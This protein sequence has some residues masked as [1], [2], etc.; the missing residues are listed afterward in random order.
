MIEHVINLEQENEEGLL[1]MTT[2][3]DQSVVASLAHNWNTKNM[4]ALRVECRMF[5]RFVFLSHWDMHRFYLETRI[6]ND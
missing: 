4:H 1:T 6:R 5:L 3:K 2:N